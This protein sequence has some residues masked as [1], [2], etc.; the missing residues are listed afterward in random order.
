MHQ[1]F[2]KGT[3][4]IH[5]V[6]NFRSLVNYL[7]EDAKRRKVSDLP[8][9]ERKKQ[10]RNPTPIPT[11]NA[12]ATAAKLDQTVLDIVSL[13]EMTVLTTCYFRNVIYLIIIY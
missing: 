1:P 6:Q 10:R 3:F 5:K 4:F 9:Q 13:A 12:T 11:A 8:Q 2:N 7:A